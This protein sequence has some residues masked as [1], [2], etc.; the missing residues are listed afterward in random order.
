MCQCQS[1]FISFKKCRKRSAVHSCAHRDIHENEKKDGRENQSFFKSWCFP[2]L[3]QIFLCGIYIL[4]FLF[5]IP[6]AG[7]VPR[8]FH[9]FDNISVFCRSLHCHGICQ[10]RNTDL[11]DTRNF[12]H[13]FFHMGTADI[14][15]HSGHCITFHSITPA[16]YFPSLH[17]FL[18]HSAKLVHLFFFSPADI[19]SHTRTDMG[20]QKQLIKTVQR[21]RH[22]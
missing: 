6:P 22:R 3:K 1:R 2:I 5:L 8:H 9:G 17:Q 18:E 12:F 14:T 19:I 15:S 16:I 4:P 10:K 13:R 11:F 21:I 7:S 20:F